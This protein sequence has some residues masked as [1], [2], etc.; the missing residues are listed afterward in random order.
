MTWRVILIE[1]NSMTTCM[2][3]WALPSSPG[4]H[5]HSNNHM[6]SCYP[7]PPEAQPPP[8]TDQGAAASC[9]Y[10]RKSHLLWL[11]DE[12]LSCDPPKSS[13]HI[14]TWGAATLWEAANLWLR[15]DYT[16]TTRG[17]ATTC[18][19]LRNRCCPRPFKEQSPTITM[20]HSIK[21]TAA[22]TDTVWLDT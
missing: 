4:F 10:L 6:N 3:N 19:T 5:D 11:W 8:V 21:P 22:A 7:W 20:Q 14:T 2:N 15:N 16:T 17:A 1:N 9:D 12:Q 18:D 13:F